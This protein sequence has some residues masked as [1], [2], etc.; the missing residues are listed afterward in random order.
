MGILLRL[1]LAKRDNYVFVDPLAPIHLSLSQPIGEAPRL[2]TSILRGLRGQTLIDVKGIVDI[3][4]G[5]L[6][7]K[8]NTTGKINQILDEQDA[9]D[10]KADNDKEAPGKT[11]SK[12][13]ADKKPGKGK[14]PTEE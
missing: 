2:T 10:D 7:S 9:V 3:E 12:Q 8:N 1:N 14:K 6:K 4:G 13:T 5:T 11:G